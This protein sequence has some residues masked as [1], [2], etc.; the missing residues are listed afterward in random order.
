MS[1]IRKR[2]ARLQSKFYIRILQIMGLC[3]AGFLV[4]CFK[5]GS[6]QAEYGVPYDEQ[7][8][9]RFF[10]TV[11]SEDSLKNI[12]AIE[13]RMVQEYGLDS[14]TTTTNING[15]FTLY[16]WAYE[17]GILK[18]KVLDKDS[19]ANVGWFENKT[20]DVEISY[21]DF[22]NSERQVDVLLKKK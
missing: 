10:G 1:K 8:E 7:R 2:A 6:P 9:I 16:N 12:P 18:L 20:V 3:G 14:V 15:E 11:K 17:G 19:I 22:N 13:L 4:A 5:Y 21:R